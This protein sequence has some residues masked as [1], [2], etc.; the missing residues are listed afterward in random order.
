M[1][2]EHTFRDRNQIESHQLSA[3]DELVEHLSH[4]NPFYQGRLAAAGLSAGVDSLESFRTRMPFTQKEQLVADQKDQPP[5][6]TNLSLPVDQY[7]RLHQT[8]GTT[9][10][11][12]HWLDSHAGWDWLTQA[13][14]TVMEAAGVTS[15]DRVF[16][17]FSFGPFLG[18]WLAFEAAQELGAM[19]LSG[20]ALNTE[21]RL[22]NLLRHQATVLCCTPTYALRL[23]KTADELGIDLSQAALQKII[24][25]GE[26]GGCLE[27]VRRQLEQSFPGARVFDHY[28]M[29]EMGPVT[30]QCLADDRSVHIA[31]A[32]YVPEVVDP[33][34]G[35]PIPH[36][37]TRQGELVLTNLGRGDSPLLR[38]RTGDLVRPMT[39]ETCA[40]GRPSMR[41]LGGILG[42]A[43]DMIVVR[44]VNLF[45]AAVDEIVLGHSS[46]GE[47]RC[48]IRS[49]RGMDEL[50][51]LLEPK[52]DASDATRTKLVEAVQRDFRLNHHLRVP[53]RIV[54]P[55]TLPRFEL[56]AHRWVRV[57]IP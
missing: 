51:V 23:A 43:D 37:G 12:M 3:L 36:D 56:K 18:L 19:A 5:Y 52:A 14:A 1:N 38:Y 50:E 44:G 48:E 55:G 10:A 13:W 27:S 45:P 9:G 20:G 33:S 29:T 31:E 26:P 49:E 41:L 35:E 42:R 30:Y 11:P 4:R 22:R 25:A 40:C 24:V 34:S 16:V 28:G 8:S 6:G 46:V 53:V 15:E 7:T 54:E 57:Q 47:F 39:T 2:R 32:F 17:A 21:G